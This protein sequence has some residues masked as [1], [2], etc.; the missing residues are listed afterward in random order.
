MLRKTKNKIFYIKVRAKNVGES[1]KKDY[2]DFATPEW[3]VNF[4]VNLIDFQKLDNS[5]NI[6]ILEPAC[7]SAQFLFTIIKKQPQLSSRAN[8][9]GVEINETTID[10]LRMDSAVPN[11]RIINA[12]YL[13]WNTNQFFDLII[14]NPPYGIPSNSKHYAI[15]VDPKIKLKYKERYETWH[16]KYNVYGAFIEKSIKLLKPGGQLIFIVPATFMIL[17]DF[18]KLREFL[19]QNGKTTIIYMGPNVFKPEADVTVVI[20]NFVKSSKA[21]SAIRTY[22]I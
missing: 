7:G 2:G 13:L 3:T 17:D 15:K 16:G 11:I 19:S 21:C 14:G 20:L 12:D 8:F 1:S 10:L 4:M 22:G 5:E 6:N 9:W 18:K